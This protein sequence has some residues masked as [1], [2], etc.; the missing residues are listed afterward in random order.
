MFTGLT[1]RAADNPFETI[2]LVELDGSFFRVSL[3]KM[4]AGMPA[5]HE[6][7]LS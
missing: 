1:G 7:T 2:K 6:R 3:V 4:C 5:F